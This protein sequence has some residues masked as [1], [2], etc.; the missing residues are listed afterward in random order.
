MFVKTGLCMQKSCL[1]AYRDLFSNDE[2]NWG[3]TI[4][5]PSNRFSGTVSSKYNFK[6]T[7]IS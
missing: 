3:E 6:H 2:K 7:S 4:P 5:A 1:D